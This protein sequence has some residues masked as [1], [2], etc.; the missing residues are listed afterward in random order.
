MYFHNFFYDQKKTFRALLIFSGIINLL[1][2]LII[3]DIPWLSD[4][5]P[6]VFGPKLYNLIN[7][8]FITLDTGYI[9]QG[10]FVP[11]Y[12]LAYQIIPD[13]YQV[14]HF[15]IVFLNFISTLFFY[16]ITKELF[17]SNKIALLS[18]L[19][20]T[21]HY[22]ITIKPLIWIAFYGHIANCFFGLASIYFFLRYLNNNKITFLIASTTSILLG[23]MIMESG[24]VYSVLLFLIVLLFKKRS[25]KNLT[26]P[27]IPI[28]IYFSISSF[29]DNSAFEFLKERTGTKITNKTITIIEDEKNKGQNSEIYWYRSTYAPRNIKG[30]SLRIFDNILSS[31]NLSSL[32]KSI[33][34]ID[35]SGVLRKAIK[36]NLSIFVLFF[37]TVFLIYIFITFRKIKQTKNYYIYLKLL[38]LY[39]SILFIYTFV[40]FRRDLAI[41]LSFPSTLIISFIFFDLIKEK[42]SKLA[43]LTLS[44]FV[45]PSIIYI[46]TMFEYFS[47]HG[48][49]KQIKDTYNLYNRELST[50][51]IENKLLSEDD[52]KYYY[53]YKNFKQ[54]KED[55]RIYKDLTY[56]EFKMKFLKNKNLK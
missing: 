17:K 12:S 29:A 34:T 33:K 51:E 32:E 42:G 8:N 9:H 25:F 2:F 46:F 7:D 48:S 19:L 16:L 14:F 3:F 38:L 53:F 56:R 31:I 21:I 27:L 20:F 43:I 11:L 37:S 15:L 41:A 23:S 13:S 47:N 39:I 1:F 55:L 22:S 28:F 49:V 5:Y 24:L 45:I 40:F 52:F 26:L 50:E 6:L 44:L 54:K 18:S 36:D 10:R 35:K 30:Y 4:D